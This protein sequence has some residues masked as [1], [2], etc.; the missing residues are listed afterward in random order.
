MPRWDTVIAGFE[1][2]DDARGGTSQA[3][4]A[5]EVTWEHFRKVLTSSQIELNSDQV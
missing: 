3:S 4:L 5:H 1:A 2:L